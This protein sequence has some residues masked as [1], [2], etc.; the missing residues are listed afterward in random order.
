VGLPGYWQKLRK[1]VEA[2][3]YL[4]SEAAFDLTCEIFIDHFQAGKLSPANQTRE[5]LQDEFLLNVDGEGRAPD[6]SNH[7]ERMFLQTAKEHPEFTKWF[8]LSIKESKPTL[9]AGRWFCHLAGLRHG[10]VEIFIDPPLLENHTLV[11]I[12]GMNKFE[13]PGAFDIS[14]AGHINGTDT[15]V[16]SLEKELAEELN[17]TLNDLNELRL[18]K[19]YNSYTGGGENKTAN[20]EYRILFRA[21]LIAKTVVDIRFQDREVAGLA[22]FSVPE[23]REIIACYPD[24]IASGLSDALIYYV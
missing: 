19:Q 8:S 23:L 17:L 14:C 2:D 24:R 15:I 21:K 5:Y 12:R 20:Y 18:I 16:R 7:I 4:L 6:I 9:L 10:T 1:Q 22:I 11:Q 13:A 3:Q